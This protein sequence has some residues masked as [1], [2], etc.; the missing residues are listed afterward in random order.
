MIGRLRSGVTVAQARAD[1][2]VIADNLAREYPDNNKHYTSALLEPQLAHL[3][4]DTRP[5]LR[6]LF[7]AVSLVLLLVCA[8]VGGLPLAHGSRRSAE[9]ALRSAIGASHAAIVRQ[10]LIEATLLSLCGGALGV[11][12][13]YGMLHAILQLV[14]VEIPRMHGAGIDANVLLF[15]LVVSLFRSPDVTSQS[16]ARLLTMWLRAFR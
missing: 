13:A 1:L 15:V 14:P 16:A 4:G 3:T 9:F 8:N 12:L 5:A 10:L 7:S 2:S 6:L 11:A